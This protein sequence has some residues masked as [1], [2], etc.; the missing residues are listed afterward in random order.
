[1][2]LTS[3]GGGGSAAAILAAAGTKISGVDL[4]LTWIEAAMITTMS[5]VASTALMFSGAFLFFYLFIVRP[6]GRR[7]GEH[8]TVRLWVEAWSGLVSLKEWIVHNLRNVN[9]DESWDEFAC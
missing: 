2:L 1:T 3:L 7:Y 9:A 6:L 5:F 8:H 4:E